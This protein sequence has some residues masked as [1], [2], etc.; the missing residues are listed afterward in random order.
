MSSDFKLKDIELFFSSKT[1]INF[2]TWKLYEWNLSTFYFWQPPPPLA[3][4]IRSLDFRSVIFLCWAHLEEDLD[5]FWTRGK[6][7]GWDIRH[8]SKRT[9]C[10]GE[11]CSWRG[12]KVGNRVGA[13]HFREAETHEIWGRAFKY[14]VFNYL[15]RVLNFSFQ[16][17]VLLP[18]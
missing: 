12:W 3:T 5:I 2:W 14:F 10:S 11:S 6:D 9:S 18:Q 8:G 4:V 1:Q 17:I 13:G 15:F 16:I 7:S